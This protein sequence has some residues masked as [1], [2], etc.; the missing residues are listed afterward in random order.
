MRSQDRKRVEVCRPIRADV[1]II[2]KVDAQR[3]CFCAVNRDRVWPDVIRSV[4]ES[5]N[6]NQ[7][8]G[9]SNRCG[10]QGE[11]RCSKSKEKCFHKLLK[12]PLM[13]IWSA[14]VSYPR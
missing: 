1:G 11:N 8:N 5:I 4:V 9:G 10:D 14:S 13:P 6:R 3:G 12:S 2:V 7:T